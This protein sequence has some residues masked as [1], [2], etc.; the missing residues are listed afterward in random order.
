M[1]T[2]FAP[3]LLERAIRIASLLAT[4]ERAQQLLELADQVWDHLVTP[5]DRRT[6]RHAAC[7]T[8]RPAR[9]PDMRTEL[10]T[11]SWYYT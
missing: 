9:S 11:P 2:D 1:A 8:S 3:L 7:G 6:A 10:P 4:P 5:P